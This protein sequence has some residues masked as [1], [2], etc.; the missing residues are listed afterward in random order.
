LAGR[1]VKNSCLWKKAS[2]AELQSYMYVALD[3]AYITKKTFESICNQADKTAKIIS[4]LIK[5]L[6]T[7]STK[8]TKSTK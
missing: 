8:G 5:Y 2:A 4:G 7:K 6:R 1:A 3:Q